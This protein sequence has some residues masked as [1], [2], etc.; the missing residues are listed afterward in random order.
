MS[1]TEEVIIDEAAVKSI[2]E[3]TSEA[4]KPELETA[5]KTAVTEALADEANVEALAKAVSAQVLKDT[6]EI[7]RKAVEKAEAAKTA[8]SFVTKGVAEGKLDKDIAAM[9]PAMR[10]FNQM[11]AL[12]EG[13][14]EVL[15]R[16]N[17]VCLATQLDAR[18]AVAK[19]KGI[20]FAEKAGYNNEATQADGSVLV[21]DAE[22][23]TT[24]YDNLP[25]YGV[26]LREA[27]VRQTDRTSVRVISLDDGLVFYS[28]AEAGV[29]TAAKLTFSKNEVSLQKYAVI[30]PATD[31]LTQDAAV[32][33]WQLVT[34]E[35]SRAYAR[36]ADEVVFTDP[37][38]GITNLSGVITT[39]VTGAGT[40]IKW[41]DLLTSEGKTEDDLDESNSK[42]Y[43]RKETWFRLIQRRAD[44]AV[45]ADGAGQFLYGSLANGWVPNPTQPTT[46]WGREVVFTRV[47][48][49]SGGITTSGTYG[50][51]VVSNNDAFAVYGDLKNYILYNKNGMALKMLTEA[52]IID[53]A[54]VSTN[55]ATQDISAMRAVIRLLG[56]CAK[57]N[58]SKF[59]VVGTGTVS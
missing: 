31:E 6:E 4:V 2:V 52:T 10:F 49:T 23:V 55:L 54:G 19:E 9:S 15:R 24:V 33:Y 16:Y 38:S 34:R 5:A 44:A 36:K 51:S 56:I 25:K 26:A 17:K 43:M 11:K 42:W 21:P 32:D 12:V 46:P 59:V 39:P 58:R 57:G 40:T 1:E 29:K 14:A 8:E 53:Q 7:E 28:T 45:A 20:D 27:D 22:F 30:V 48:P 18:A 13:N 47:L 37:V 50:S 3:K 35:L 41:E